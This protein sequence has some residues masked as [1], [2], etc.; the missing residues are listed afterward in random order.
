MAL[1]P[2]IGKGERVDLAY[3]DGSHLF[4]DVF[5]DF[6]LVHRLLS[7]NG[8]IVFD[9]CTDPHVAKVCGFIQANASKQ[10]SEMDL[11]PFRSQQG[12][13]LKHT[14][15]KKF[16]RT[17]MRAF[18]KISSEANDWNYKLKDF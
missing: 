14:L 4:E 17:Q 12:R 7:Q 18:R 9:D 15:A 3:I 8:V 5:I 1:P 10:Y 11:T 2:K 16:G 13:N 6:V